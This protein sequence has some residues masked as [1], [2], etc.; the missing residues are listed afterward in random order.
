MY[1]IDQRL[2]NSI[3]QERAAEV[4]QYLQD[5]ANRLAAIPARQRTWREWALL[6]LTFFGR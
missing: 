1:H 2:I 6:V 3:R 4:D 5:R